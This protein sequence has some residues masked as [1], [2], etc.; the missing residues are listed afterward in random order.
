[1]DTLIS[2]F[3]FTLDQTLKI[4]FV[5]SDKQKSSSQSLQSSQYESLKSETVATKKS[6]SKSKHQSSIRKVKAE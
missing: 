3:T 5:T 6:S 4:L 2:D 1:M